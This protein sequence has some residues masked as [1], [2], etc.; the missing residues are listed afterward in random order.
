MSLTPESLAAYLRGINPAMQADAIDEEQQELAAIVR[1]EVIENFNNEQDSD[2]SPW[3][4]RVGNPQHLPLRKTYSM[5]GA[6]TVKGAPGSV[7]IRSR[8]ELVVGVSGSEIE[9]AP[10]QNYGGGR[11]PAR[12]FMYVRYERQGKFD[13]PVEMAM[14]RVELEHLR[15]HQA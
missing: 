13:G 8:E 9:H 7:E 12:E 6:A 14:R 2:G 15:R 1:D 11:V 3:L 10:I 4:P 5:F